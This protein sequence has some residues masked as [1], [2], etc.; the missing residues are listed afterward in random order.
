MPARY[1]KEILPVWGKKIKFFMDWNPVD[2][3]PVKME[4]WPHT[5]SEWFEVYFN[6]TG[7]TISSFSWS[8]TPAT[9]ILNYTISWSFWSIPANVIIPDATATA[10]WLINTVAQTFSWDKT[11]NANVSVLGN[12]TLGNA[13][14]DITSVFGDLIVQNRFRTANTLQLTTSAANSTTNLVAASTIDIYSYIQINQ[15]NT[16]ATYT[17][18]NPTAPTRGIHL[19]ISN[20][21]T[22]AFV[23]DWHI[24]NPQTTIHFIFDGAGWSETEVSR[25]DSFVTVTATWT[26]PN[27]VDTVIINNWATAITLTMPAKIAWKTVTLM[28]GIGSTWGI[29]VNPWWWQIEALANTLWATTTLAASGA[30]GQNVT[31]I[32]DGTN[33]LR[34]NNG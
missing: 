16:G 31:F 21:G 6:S 27:T 25:N 24:I 26:I 3:I 23:I 19:W 12:T 8:F 20:T 34:K 15:T 28:R 30:Y 10:R 11:F 17:I 2:V 18:P 5:W 4:D 1:H 22:Q 14:T 9:G 13:A 7:S 32:T 33:W 29:T